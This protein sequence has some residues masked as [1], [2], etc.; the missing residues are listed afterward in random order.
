MVK[1]NIE[2]RSDYIFT[3]N[4]LPLNTATTDILIAQTRKVPSE[5]RSAISG[6]FFV[7]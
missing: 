5:Q 3:Y 4:L 7:Q 2:L 1:K 6:T